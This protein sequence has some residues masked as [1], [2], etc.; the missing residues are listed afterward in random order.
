MS[1]GKQ[2]LS[3]EVLE[4]ILPYALILAAVI[5]LYGKSV[6]FDFIPSWDD[7]VYVLNNLLIQS[8]SVA[9]LKAIFTEPFFSNYAPVNLLSYSADYLFWGLNPAGYHIM[10]VV[11]HAANV[12]LAFVVIKR[13]AKRN[14]VAFISALIFAVHPVNVENVAWV[15]ERKTLLSVLFTFLSLLTYLNFRE[16]GGKVFNY[17]L[18]LIFFIL[19]VLSK[20][21]AVTLPLALIA[22]EVF[23]SGERKWKYSL[24]F[25]AVSIAGTLTVFA[26]LSSNN[27][28]LGPNPLATLFGVVYPTM[29]PIYWRYIWTIIWPLNLSGFYDAPYYHSFLAPIVLASLFGWLALSAIILW[30]GSNRV[31]FW[32]LWFWV[33]LLPV[34]NIIPIPVFYAERYMYLPALGAFALFAMLITWIFGGLDVR[35]GGTTAKKA[36]GYGLVAVVVA[37]YGI[38][39]FDRLDVW[40]D[41]LVFWEDTVRK[42]PNQFKPHVNLGYAY[43]VRGSYIEAEREYETAQRIYPGDEG[44]LENLRMVRIKKMMK[45]GR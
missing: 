21:S 38:T 11:I 1:T 7:D 18:G 8:F 14:D 6:G 12:L 36:V 44:V 35:V 10:N 31:R 30:K 16:R 37:F 41:E 23:I 4:K 40:R 5:S 42:S 2:A 33:W 25:F 24:P 29:L 45:Y 28:E 34:S 17:V 3:R 19:A 26:H 9:N 13:I 43:D 20:S 39:A 15:S 32:Y 22:Y 27:I